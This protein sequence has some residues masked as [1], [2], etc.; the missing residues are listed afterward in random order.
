MISVRILTVFSL[1]AFFVFWLVL[2]F[3]FV[4]NLISFDSQYFG[5]H[6]ADTENWITPF[7]GRLGGWSLMVIFGGRINQLTH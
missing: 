1:H 4:I 2:L 7:Y 3:P 6:E 5:I